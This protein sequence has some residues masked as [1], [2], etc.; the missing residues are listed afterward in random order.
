MR[1]KTTEEHLRIS[2]DAY[3]EAVRYSQLMERQRDDLRAAL[4]NMLDADQA[5]REFSELR[6]FEDF[7]HKREKSVI[8]R[9][10]VREA[11][12]AVPLPETLALPKP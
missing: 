2:E 5:L 1:A 10:E 6:D 12:S 9:R 8:A 7:H 4:Q 3:N 11:L